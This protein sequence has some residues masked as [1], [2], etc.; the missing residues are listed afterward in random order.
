MPVT[1]YKTL[2][3]QLQPDN[4]DA[5]IAEVTVAGAFYVVAHK[6]DFAVFVD[7]E[8]KEVLS[9]VLASS[10]SVAASVVA[11]T[12]WIAEQQ[13]AIFVTPAGKKLLL[14]KV[15][16]FLGT[17]LKTFGQLDD[18]M[19]DDSDDEKKD[20][21]ETEDK[22][23][24]DA[25]EKKDADDEPGD[26]DANAASS[27]A[28]QMQS[29]Q[30]L[31]EALKGLLPSA[32]SQLTQMGI[33]LR[34]DEKIALHVTARALFAPQEALS[35]WAAK[36]KPPAAGLLAGLPPGKFVV[37]YGAVW[38]TMSPEFSKLMNWAMQSSVAQLGLDE[39]Q[40]KKYFAAVERQRANQLSTSGLV[41]NLHPGDTL[42]GTSL[43]MEY[44]KSA[45]EHIK[46]TRE[47]F[48]LLQSVK[49]EGRTTK[50]P[51]YEVK[52][53]MLGDLKALEITTDMLS[54]LENVE[55]GEAKEQVEGWFA[56]FF[57]G[58]GLMRAYMVMANDHTV[59]TAYSKQL[60]ER[61]VQHVRSARLGWKPIAKS[62][63]RPL[64][65]PGSQWAIYI[66]PQGVIQLIDAVL[67]D[68]L[69]P[70]TDLKIPPF[71]P[72]DPIG[73]AAQVAES[74]L[75]AE[76]VL[77]GSVVAGIGQYIGLVQQIMQGEGARRCLKQSGS[78]WRAPRNPATVI[79]P[80]QAREPLFASGSVSV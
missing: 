48:E 42:V 31:L 23:K 2:I 13:A 36:V 3:K 1:D 74:G 26:K 54:L 33:G 58:G 59:V 75:D 44:V 12:P 11:V 49:A 70:G 17:G 22:D 41:G 72:S 32:D 20:D 15:D 16:E 24:Q 21:A 6:G 80:V 53:V 4:A 18:E 55:E 38:A 56:K 5:E 68:M 69:P 61:G 77:P 7:A 34:I 9:K 37:A 46:L 78:A 76:L 30:Q 62:P 67:R 65:P 60:V 63:I 71:P 10:K 8:Q 40:T 28:A 39:E 73:L 50:M 35:R 43:T 52:D 29:I 19:Q 25:D 79:K 47:M 64:L 51:T 27:V 57:G 45:S 14:K 66:S